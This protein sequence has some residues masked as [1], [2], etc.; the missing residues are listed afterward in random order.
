MKNSKL[1]ICVPTFNRSNLLRTLITSIDDTYKDYLEIIIVDDGSIDDTSKVCSEYSKK[2]NI[3][4]YFQENAGR[5]HALHKAIEESTSE[6]TIIMDSDDKFESNG[7]EKILGHITKFSEKIYQENI[8][9][10]VM[11]CSNGG[12]TIGSQFKRHVS[13]GNILRDE[14]DGKIYGDKKQIIR[15]NILKDF[16]YKPFPNE[17]RMA[18]SIIWNRLSEEYSVMN[19]NEVVASKDYLDDGLTKNINLIRALSPNSSS[20]YYLEAFSLYSKVYKS[21]FFAMRMGI[22]LLRY[23]LHL[24]SLFYIR[25]VNLLKLRTILIVASPFAIYLFLKDKTENR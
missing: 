8:A 20:L 5:S 25:K 15:T 3:K 13:I 6:F 21:I 23:S 2:F 9:G 7:I 17:K 11:L 1:S 12:K 19:I 4:Y 16:L 22:N 18:T 10:F 24:N 14:A